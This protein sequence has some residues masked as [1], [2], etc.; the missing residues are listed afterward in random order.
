LNADDAREVG[1]PSM[2]V[3]TLK[4]NMTLALRVTIETEGK[5]ALIGDSFEVTVG[6]ARSL[7]SEQ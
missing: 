1:A 3:I 6:G 7:L 2:D 5:L 4:E